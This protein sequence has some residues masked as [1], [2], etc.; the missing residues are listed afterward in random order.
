MLTTITLDILTILD[1][2]YRMFIT[3]ARGAPVLGHDSRKV[4]EKAAKAILTSGF[5]SY[6]LI[7]SPKRRPNILL[8]VRRSCS[9]ND[10]WLM[11]SSAATSSLVARCGTSK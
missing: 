4:S 7:D 2:I 9:L 8:S 5:D 3:L 1:Y 10:G 6:W 11:P